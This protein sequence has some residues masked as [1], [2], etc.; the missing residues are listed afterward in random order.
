MTL[1][2]ENVLFA[3]LLGA[4]VAQQIP[5]FGAV[6]NEL[7]K[8]V[9]PPIPFLPINNKPVK[10]GY[11]DYTVMSDDQLW[12]ADA[13]KSESEQFFPFTWI[14]DGGQ[15]YLLPYEPMISISTKNNIAERKVAKA[16]DDI[17]R[18]GTVKERWSADDYEIKITGVLIGSILTGDVSKCFPRSDFQ[19]LNEVL[20][21]RKSWEILCEPLQLLGI[22][23]V[24]VYDMNFP[25]TKGEN[26]QA[27]EMSIKS[28]FDFDLLLEEEDVLQS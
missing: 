23:R 6:Q 26:V 15:R 8:H 28:D 13:P 20:R 4:K 16:G 18:Q 27:Y 17:K 9:L 22:N 25:F 2:N 5:R 7:G 1:S 11:P 12:R 10:V 21:K 19:K 24:V 3:S 14:G